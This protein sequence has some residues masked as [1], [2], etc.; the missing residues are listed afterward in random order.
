LETI[1]YIVFG[2]YLT[3]ILIFGLYIH[4]RTKTADDYFLAGRSMNWFPIGLSV[5][6]T[7]FSSINYMALPSEVFK[8]GFY[9][10]IALPVFFIVGF[11]ITRIVMPFYHK[12]QVTT[13]YE[14]LELRFDLRVRL[15]ASGMFILWRMIWIAVA[16]FASGKILHAT[17]GLSLVGVILFSGLI[18]TT[19]TALGGIRAVMWTDVV[20]FFILF[21]SILASLVA[22]TFIIP[23]GLETI[24]S[25]SVNGGLLKP[26][27]PFDPEF[28]SFDPQVRISFW[29]GLTGVTVAFLARYGAD[30]VVVQRYFTARPLKDAQRGYW[31][32]ASS[33]F[34]SIGL[35][36]L[37]GMVI[38]SYALNTAPTMVNKMPPLKH[39]GNLIQQ[40]PF[41][42]C[43]LVVAGLMSATMSSVDSGVNACTTAWENDFHKRLINSES[44]EL[45]S[46]KRMILTALLG[47]VATGAALIFI[48]VLG[49]NKSLFV[50]INKLINGLGSPLLALFI[51]GMFF[52]QITAR[53]VFYG[54]IAG[55]G[56]SI[57]ISLFVPGIALHY[58]A[59][60]NLIATLI[61][62]VVFSFLFKEN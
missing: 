39:M 48:P 8:N 15:L 44:N 20:Q 47:I 57:Y 37:F 42:I 17:T 55:T 16:L 58:Y 3:G 26:V 52:K 36:A 59:V 9:V 60:I 54:G 4:S 11:P 35:L 62:C 43:G 14:Y 41:G 7:A 61:P 5:M 32:N 27:Y 30:Q 45:S 56:A 24:F 19:Y 34:I 51:C 13:A 1:D 6:A 12:L 18:A 49:P 23:G 40:L 21:G 22:A 53:G 50:M 31:L 25:D 10:A 46:S 33:A 2:A 29:S 38:H 28:F